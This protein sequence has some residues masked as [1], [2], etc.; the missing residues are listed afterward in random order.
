[1]VAQTKQIPTVTDMGPSRQS[2]WGGSGQVKRNVQGSCLASSRQVQAGSGKS[3][4]INVGY[5]LG[6]VRLVDVFN[7][8]VPFED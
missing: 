4:G 5:S 2:V 6:L 1:M 8:F 3:R 7:G